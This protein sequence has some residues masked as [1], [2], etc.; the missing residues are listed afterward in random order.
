MPVFSKHHAGIAKGLVPLY[1]RKRMVDLLF[2]NERGKLDGT[3]VE[4]AKTA[5]PT[6]TGPAITLADLL[7]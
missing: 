2:F 7:A 5:Q 3:V 6:E 4:P 1:P